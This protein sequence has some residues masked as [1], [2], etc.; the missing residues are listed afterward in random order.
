[1]KDIFARF[2]FPEEIV[3]DNRKQFVSEEF[4]AFLQARGIK[5]VRVSPYYVRSN[6]KLARFHRYLKKHFRAVISEGKS[7]QEALPKIFMLYQ[8]SPHPVS[9]KSPTAVVQSR[10]L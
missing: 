4:E 3:S 1:M 8:A 10:N 7:W 9:G 2:G 6:G 5:H